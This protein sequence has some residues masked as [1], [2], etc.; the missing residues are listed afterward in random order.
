MESQKQISAFDASKFLNFQ[1]AKVQCITLDQLK[2]TYKENDVY[3]NPLK[4]MYHC[5]IVQNVLDQ[6]HDLGYKTEIYDMFAAHNS[7]R[8]NPGVVILPQIENE[9]GQ[10]AVEAHILR[11]VFTNV[12]LLDFDDDTYTTNLSIAF[13]QR[14][15]QVG[16]GNNVKICHNQCMLNADL[17]AATYSE[18][19]RNG[20]KYDLPQML[21]LVRSWLLDARHLVEYDRER[22][23]R[24]KSINVT[25]EKTFQ[26]IVMLTS[27]R[28]AHDTK[29]KEIRQGGYYPLNQSQICDFTEDL[30]LRYH[31][32]SKVTVWDLYDAATMLYKADKMDMPSIMPQNRAFVNFLEENFSI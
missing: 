19:G 20:V 1:E 12:R 23:E 14:G 8:Q 32:T 11:R 6:C 9:K 30:M 21:D 15:V 13:H 28:V 27:T 25:P 29:H 2:S 17:Y 4:G 7:D 24:M 3:G 10:R 18:N 22:I 5:D 16:F 26:L 31:N